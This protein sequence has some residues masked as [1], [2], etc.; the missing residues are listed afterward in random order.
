MLTGLTQLFAKPNIF[1]LK[2]LQERPKAGDLKDLFDKEAYMLSKFGKEGTHNVR[3]LAKIVE[4]D[5]IGSRHTYS[6]L[7]P[8]AELDLG[9]YWRKS[10]IHRDDEPL[11]R[12]EILWIAEQCYGLAKTL[13]HIHEPPELLNENGKQ[14]FGRHGDIKPENIL[15]FKNDKGAM[16]A[17]ADMG[18]TRVHKD[19]SR[20]NIPG[21]G[22]PQ[23]PTYRPP[24]CDM[25]GRE[26]YISRSF[27]IWTLGCVFLEFIVW[28]LK[29]H[30]FGIKTFQEDRFGKYIDPRAEVNMFFSLHCLEDSTSEF[31][32]KVHDGVVKVR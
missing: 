13:S 28:T 32:F 18:L 8:W 1:A 23:T 29:G 24:E 26:G 5:T 19:S 6:L 31:A 7:F 11:F 14:L 9:Q 17:F 2:T 20:S 16:L 21:Q 3:L 25:A 12:S 30:E 4:K 22:I 10:H 27:D 15:W